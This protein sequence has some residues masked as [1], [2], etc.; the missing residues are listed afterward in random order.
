MPFSDSNTSIS[1]HVYTWPSL[2]KVAIC[3]CVAVVATVDSGYQ[4]HALVGTIAKIYALHNEVR[5]IP[6]VKG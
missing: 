2:S 4:A 6:G 3:T 5:Y 1:L